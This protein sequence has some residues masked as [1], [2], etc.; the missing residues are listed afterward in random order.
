M[1]YLLLITEIPILEFQHSFRL[2]T[3][4][5]YV[6]KLAYYEKRE[7]VSPQNVAANT[8]TVNDR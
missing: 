4:K 5:N 6:I 1:F 8:E 7:I 2:K 3:F